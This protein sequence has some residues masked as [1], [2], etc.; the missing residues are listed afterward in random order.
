MRGV[1]SCRLLPLRSD[2]LSRSLIARQAFGKLLQELLLTLKNSFEVFEPGFELTTVTRTE[3]W[4]FALFVLAYLTVTEATA[5]V[6]L[7]SIAFYLCQALAITAIASPSRPTFLCLH[8][9]QLTLIGCDSLGRFRFL[10]VPFSFT[11]ESASSSLCSTSS[12]G[13]VPPF[14]E[15]E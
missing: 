11:S 14:G 8:F 15:F 2:I 13:T 3:T 7:T 1:R 9:S 6:W 10:V 12:L 5:T 4:F